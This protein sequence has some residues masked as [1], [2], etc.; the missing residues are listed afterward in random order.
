MNSAL[1]NPISLAEL[2][3]SGSAG[4]HS[5]RHHYQR[6]LGIV[7][8]DQHEREMNGNA[9]RRVAASAVVGG[10]ILPGSKQNIDVR[11][12][13]TNPDSLRHHSSAGTILSKKKRVF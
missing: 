4:T 1:H 7:Y 6:L 9:A 3:G 10:L 2:V 13:M 11:R 12:S 8:P 5:L